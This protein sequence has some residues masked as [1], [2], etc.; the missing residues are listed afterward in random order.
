MRPVD[1]AGDAA[2]EGLDDRARGLHR[3]LVWITFFRV[4]SITVLLGGTAAVGW[5]SAPDLEATAPLYTLVIATY[6]VSV[7]FALALRARRLLVPL[8]Y[9]QLA[10]DVG[11]AAAVVA[12]TGGAESVFVFMYSLGIVNGAILLYRRGALTALAVALGA[13]LVV[14][15][16]PHHGHRAVPVGLLFVH[17]SA[18]V[19]TAVLASYLAE[20]L[21]RTG[22]RLAARES[23]LAE[24]TALHEAIVQSVTSGLV[25][26]DRAGRVTFLNRAGE[27]MLGVLA[28]DV[29]GRPA[30]G[31]LATIP[32][33]VARGELDHLIGG[34]ESLRLGY[35]SFQLIGRDGAAVG[36]ALIFQDLTQLRAMEEKVARSERLADL[37]GVAA[38]LAH[39]LR[40]PLASMMGA[41][42]LLRQ[43]PGLA[44][45]DRRLME[46]A[47]RESGRL[48]ELVTQFLA[49]ARP[50]PPRRVRC[51]LAPVVDETLDVLAN[52]P[53]LAPVDVERA[54][55]PAPAHCDPDQLRQI[56]LN[57]VLNAAHAAGDRHPPPARGRVRVA[58]GFDAIGTF[59]AV[60]DDGPGVDPADRDRIFLPFFTTKQDGTGL[61]LATVQRIVDAHGGSVA[62]EGAAAGGARFVVHFP[63]PAD[64][65]DAD[66][67]AAG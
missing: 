36:K 8:A 23:D 14:A 38:G 40:N 21:R 44:G 54:L 24:I 31:W 46:I 50:A 1:A 66:A 35:S 53:A 26:L 43:A 6:A 47:L 20:Q 48:G 51:D 59:V 12:L 11:I 27:H 18:F 65:A 49:F 19:V 9:G 52:D 15:L 13:H 60:E 55:A 30:T 32:A 64:A 67:R 61:G 29:V 42:E 3:K 28:T 63:A 62:L 56:V 57:L 2:A 10:L 45:E 33:D 16:L 41:L 17:G 22:E 58:C 25:T 7:A 34:A 39:E 37:G 4:V 5:E